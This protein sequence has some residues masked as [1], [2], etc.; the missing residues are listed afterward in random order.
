MDP[1]PVWVG[2]GV[3][4]EVRLKDSGS[5]PRLEDTAILYHFSRGFVAGLSSVHDGI[6]MLRCLFL[7][8]DRSISCLEMNVMVQARLEMDRGEFLRT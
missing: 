7:D 1:V 3:V 6:G 8:G 5:G 4:E 2:P